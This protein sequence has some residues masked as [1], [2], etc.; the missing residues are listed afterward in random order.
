M[1][2]KFGP[3]IIAFGC[4]RSDSHHTIFKSGAKLQVFREFSK[5][6]HNKLNKLGVRNFASKR[7]QSQ[8]CLNYAEREQ[9]RR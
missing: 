2:L 1:L 3:I 6:F 7:G 5:L 4:W 9:N 8:T